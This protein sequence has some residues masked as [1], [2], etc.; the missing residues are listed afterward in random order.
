M[1]GSCTAVALVA[2]IALSSAAAREAELARVTYSPVP[3][4]SIVQ[5]RVV[6]LAGEAMHAQWR[7]VISKRPV[8]TMDNGERSYQYYLSLYQIRG[9]TYRLRFQSPKDGGPLTVLA[10]ARGA[11]VWFPF[12]SARIVGTGELLAPAVQQVVVQSH[13]MAADCGVATVTVFAYDKARG[14][15]VPTAIVRNPCDLEASIVNPAAHA[16]LRLQ[17]PYYARDAA[18]CCPTKPKAVA[19]LRYIRG[20]WVEE[21]DYFPLS[22]K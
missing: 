15:V 19:T 20:K 18:L 2:G 3:P 21:P 14:R 6:Y 11:N 9:S 5:S 12:Q 13:E 7:A 22:R 1:R 10:K 4:G 17:G 8:G 16:E